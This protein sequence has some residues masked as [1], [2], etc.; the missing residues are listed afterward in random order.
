MF[1]FFLIRSWE[2]KKEPGTTFESYNSHQP[3]N[4]AWELI[5]SPGAVT[6]SG[7]K[8]W[9]PGVR[10]LGAP[11]LAFIHQICVVKD[12]FWQQVGKCKEKVNESV[13]FE[14]LL[15]LIHKRTIHLFSNF[16]QLCICVLIFPFQFCFEVYWTFCLIWF[17]HYAHGPNFSTLH[18]MGLSTLLVYSTS[19]NVLELGKPFYIMLMENY[20]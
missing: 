7:A 3:R 18:Q 6:G 12:H 9:E 1:F 2:L 10:N 19:R 16:V 5:W 15:H 20:H 17:T 11:I 14:D 4:H 13:A 8:P